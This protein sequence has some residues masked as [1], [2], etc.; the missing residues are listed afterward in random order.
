[1]FSSQGRIS[2]F[3]FPSLDM[4]LGRLEDGGTGYRMS[5]R[6]WEWRCRR[7]LKSVPASHQSGVGRSFHDS[8]FFFA[9]LDIGFVFPLPW[10]PHGSHTRPCPSSSSTAFSATKVW[11]QSEEPHCSSTLPHP[12]GDC[13]LVM[14]RVC[15]CFDGGLRCDGFGCPHILVSL[16]PGS[17]THL[18]DPRL[19]LVRSLA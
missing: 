11:L 4:R 2:P 8:L 9:T 17:L 1:M 7:V 14:A 18:K 5:S 3:C 12:A 16:C 10:E 13:I 15:V 19:H 6:H